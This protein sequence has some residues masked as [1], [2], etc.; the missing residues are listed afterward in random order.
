MDSEEE[1]KDIQIVYR[2]DNGEIDYVD[3]LALLNYPSKVMRI[4][5]WFA[6]CVEYGKTLG[7]HIEDTL[8]ANCY[9]DVTFGD[10]KNRIKDFPYEYIS[11]SVN[12]I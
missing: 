1:N 4:G 5:F 2:K 10:Y 11:I 12:N 6:L 3:Y 7:E 8:P 9:L